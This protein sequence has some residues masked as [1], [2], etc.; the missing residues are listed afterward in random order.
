M[1]KRFRSR[2]RAEVACYCRASRTCKTYTVSSTSRLPRL[3][4]MY[5]RIVYLLTATHDQEMRA[6]HEA[7]T[8]TVWGKAITAVAAS[9]GMLKVAHSYHWTHTTISVDPQINFLIHGCPEAGCV[10][11]VGCG[12]QAGR[13]P[14]RWRF[15]CKI[16][17]CR[18]QAASANLHHPP[19][20]L[21]ARKCITSATNAR[22]YTWC[23]RCD[24]F[25]HFAPS[26]A[27]SNS[28]TRTCGLVIQELT[29]S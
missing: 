28:P 24:S 6:Q 13:C 7:P 22:Q 16:A 8:T 14:K 11:L 9:S 23:F 5:E 10:A 19:T 1:Q 4:D 26:L 18:R 27:L 21:P 25:R 29:R 15:S 20:L 3:V 2:D 12:Y 17:V